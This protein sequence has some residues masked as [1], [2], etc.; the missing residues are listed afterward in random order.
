MKIS[1]IFFGT[2]LFSFK[3]RLKGFSPNRGKRLGDLGAFELGGSGLLGALGHWK[4]FGN[5]SKFFEIL[6]TLEILELGAL[7]AF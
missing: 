7:E 3:T 1:L 2:P 4:H 5:F 6:E